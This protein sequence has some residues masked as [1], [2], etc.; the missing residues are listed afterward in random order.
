VSRLV[1]SEMCIRDRHYDYGHCIMKYEDIKVNM[2]VTSGTFTGVVTI[3]N[4]VGC[5]KPIVVNSRST[6]EF[7]TRS[8]WP[9][10]LELI[11]ET[12]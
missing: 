4:E 10:E 6:K 3:I 9:T 1:G 5:H 7:G 2:A 8:F 11:D 12:K